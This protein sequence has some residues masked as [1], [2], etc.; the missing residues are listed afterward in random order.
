MIS[1]RNPQCVFK[2]SHLIALEIGKKMDPNW[3]IIRTES[4]LDPNKLDRNKTGSEFDNQ[5]WIRNGT[6]QNL[7]RVGK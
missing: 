7:I 3:I 4:E 2:V 6:E 1:L 5:N